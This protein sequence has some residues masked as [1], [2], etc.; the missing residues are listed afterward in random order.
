MI[1]GTFPCCNGAY[2]FAIPEGQSLPVYF[3]ENCP[4]CEAVV[5]H[6]ISKWDPMTWVESE[7][8][9][10]FTVNDDKTITPKKG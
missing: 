2:S 10:E 9:E 7:F 8:L 6:K 1:F 4:H 3:K 5:W